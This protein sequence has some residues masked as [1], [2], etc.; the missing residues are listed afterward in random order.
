MK[1]RNTLNTKYT[2]AMLS[3]YLILQADVKKKERR[4]E[5]IK[6]ILKNTGTFITD[7]FACVVS[8]NERRQLVSIDKAKDIVGMSFLESKG[9][10]SVSKYQTVS[11][12]HRTNI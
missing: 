8:T 12:T 2:E 3:E 11:V 5:E 9:L 6:T 10:I 4:I 1:D 7:N